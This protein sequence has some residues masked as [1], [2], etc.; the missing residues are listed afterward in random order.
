MFACNYCNSQIDRMVPYRGGAADQSE[1]IKM[2]K[3]VGSDLDNFGCPICG[4]TDR[5]RHLK[6]YLT[7]LKI[8]KKSKMHVLHFAPE[9]KFLNFIKDLNPEIH[10]L[11]DLYPNS[12]AVKSIDICNIPYGDESFDLVI[13][14]HILEHVADYRMALSE[15]NRVLK[16]DGIALI[17]TPYSSKLCKTFEDAGIDSD[18]D[19]L[20]YY[21]QEDHARLFGSDIFDLYSDYLADGVIW[22]KDIFDESSNEFSVNLDEPLFFV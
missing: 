9:F 22:H 3:V 14:N 8:F 10:V 12:P 15:I 20:Y 2:A 5:E 11:A 4:S 16:R 13:A 18:T 19:K 6:Q 7:E 17:Q 1:F 21:G